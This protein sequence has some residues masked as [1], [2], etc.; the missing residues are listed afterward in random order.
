MYVSEGPLATIDDRPSI[1]AFVPAWDKTEARRRGYERKHSDAP[2]N[3]DFG[4]IQF[5]LHVLYI[6]KVSECDKLTTSA[7][8]SERKQQRVRLHP[9]AAQVAQHEPVRHACEYQPPH[10]APMADE[11]M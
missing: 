2:R 8:E 11:T 3:P 7:V 10:E 6:S 5:R 9:G 1:L 4:Q